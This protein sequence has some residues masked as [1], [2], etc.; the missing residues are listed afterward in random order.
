MKVPAEQLRG[1]L[2]LTQV[3]Y[4]EGKHSLAIVDSSLQEAAA[5]PETGNTAS[6]Q[7]KIDNF[8]FTPKLI[9]VRT[10]AEVTW[11]NHDDIPHNVIST[12]KSFA[13]PVLDTDEKFSYTFTKPGEFP[14]YCSIHPHM[15]GK[16]VARER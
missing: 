3:Q 8:S 13:S 7:V 15:T 1:Y 14:Y 9:T 12:N 16:V 11:V 4:I 6:L 10:G 2:G 5:G